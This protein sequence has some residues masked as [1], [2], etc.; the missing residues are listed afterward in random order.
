MREDRYQ[1]TP[2]RDAR[3]R[4]ERVQR[5][6]LAAAVGAARATEAQVAAAAARV[7]AARTA[8]EAARSAHF[9]TTA[10]ALAIRERFLSRRRAELAAA[11]DAQL[12]AQAAHAG[13]LGKVSEQQARLTLA[14]A[15]REVIERHFARWRAA[16]AKLVERREE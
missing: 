2:L 14:R 16:R 15:E 8:L 11:N 9:G 5:G 6:D 4:E 12:R 10:A 1:L 3:A 13:Q 7:T